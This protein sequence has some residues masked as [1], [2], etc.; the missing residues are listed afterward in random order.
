V[1]LLLL[2]LTVALWTWPGSAV[3]LP[4]TPASDADLPDAQQQHPPATPQ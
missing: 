3:L 2:L 1:L 4:A